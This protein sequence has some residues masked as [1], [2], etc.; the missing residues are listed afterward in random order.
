MQIARAVAR[1]LGAAGIVAVAG[2]TMNLQRVSDPPRAVAVTTPEHTRSMIYLLRTDRGVVVVDLGW[3]GAERALRGGLRRMDAQPADVVAV[4]LTHSHRDHLAGWRTVRHAPFV[5]HHD[6]LPHLWGEARHR[7][8][9]SRLADRLLGR[10]SLPPDA[11]RVHSFS[12]DSTLVFGR[13]TIRAFHIPGHT[14]GSAAFLARGVLFV[15]DALSYAGAGELQQASRSF[16]ADL[17]RSRV[18]MASLVERLRPHRVEWVCTAHA[19]C[20]RYRTARQVMS[21]ERDP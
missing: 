7:D 11:V 5:L 2:C 19:K 15:G 1:L 16:A 9:P 18:S 17:E 10:G 4:L 6:E 21:S 12:A 3:V 13:D 14:A 8:R 20:V